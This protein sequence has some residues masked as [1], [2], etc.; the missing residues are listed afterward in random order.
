MLPLA[1]VVNEG[2][3]RPGGFQRPRFCPAGLR[4]LPPSALRPPHLCPQDRAD[5]L[6]ALSPPAL[7]APSPSGRSHGQGGC[8][9][10]W[11][12][13]GGLCWGAAVSEPQAGLAL[14]KRPSFG[15]VTVSPWR[16][17]GR[18]AAPLR[19]GFIP[20]ELRASGA[21]LIRTLS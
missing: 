18:P 7:P 13:R 12:R 20:W 11:A 21:N 9:K 10:A 17:R 16:C 8:S 14:A 4:P 1:Q 6:G 5:L 15:G 2:A 19:T 3:F